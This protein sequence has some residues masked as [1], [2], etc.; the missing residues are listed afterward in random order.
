MQ[1]EI[2]QQQQQQQKLSLLQRAAIKAGGVKQLMALLTPEEREVVQYSWRLLARPEQIPGDLLP[3]GQPWSFWLYLAGRGSGKTRSGAEKVLDL[4]Q[5]GYR[6][7][8]FI[9]RT[10]ADVRDTL[11]EGEAGILTIAPPWLRPDYIP[12]KRRLEWKAVSVMYP[13]GIRRRSAA[14]VLT[15][16]GDEPDQL[17]GPNFDFGW[18][19]ELAAWKYLDEAWANFTMGLRLM[20]P[21][22]YQPVAIITTTPRP[23]K[24]LKDLKKDPGTLITTGTTYDNRANLAPSFYRQIISRYEGTRLGRQELLAEILDD[25]PSALFRRELL[26]RDR[27][28]E[29]SKVPLIMRSCIAIDPAVT[30]GEESADTGLMHVGMDGSDPPH[31]YVMADLTCHEKPGVWA[32]RAVRA[33]CKNEC[34]MIVGEVNNGGDMVEAVIRNIKLDV[35]AG[36]TTD[37]SDIPYTSVRATRGK[38]LRAEPV[39]TISEQGRLHLVG[40]YPELE[41]QLCQW[42]P[43]LKEKSPDRMDALVWGVTYLMGEQSPRIRML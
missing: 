20:T 30:S 24:A 16:S 4:V 14:Q 28:K 7:G 33:Y 41:D 42:S 34:D 40:T 13:S 2:Q 3:T 9:A 25:N 32:H 37:G 43:D 8:A 6:S 18:A 29:R 23:L 22:G 38:L 21:T 1:D 36:I 5:K 12:S 39:S 11:I 35:A 19:D 27:L 31:Y 17:R 15:F 10:A 26:D